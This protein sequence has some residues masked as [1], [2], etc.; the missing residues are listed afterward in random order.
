MS[1]AR[2]LA[3]AIDVRVATRDDAAALLQ[4]HHA[5][6]G[7]DWSMEQWRWRFLDNPLGRTAIAGAFAADGRCLAAFCGVPLRCRYRG[8]AGEVV[9]AGDVVVEPRLRRSIAGSTL[10]VRTGDLFFKQFG[11]GPVRIV[12]GC[13][14]PPLL[15]TATRHLRCE[16]LGDLHGL[17]R[18][19][20]PQVASPPGPGVVHE[21]RLPADVAA[22][23][24]RCASQHPT[25]LL[26]DTRYLAWRY[27]HN[28]HFDYAVHS[29]RAADG[30]LRGLAIVRSGGVHPEALS[31]VEW[32][33]P[34]G[35]DLAEQALVGSALAE[36]RTRG[37]AFVVASFPPA[38]REFE[39][40]Q[41]AHGFRVRL[42]PHQL[43]FRTYS[44]GVDRRFLFEE[45][46]YTL[47][48]FDF[49]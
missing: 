11:G 5:G 43:V 31:V 49:A 15:R 24:A 38:T 21:N 23:C 14:E 8:E 7:S 16:I 30:T 3:Q 27:A 17:V 19:V 13:P 18:A 32:L 46:F 28:P 20:Q 37:L 22:L 39:R 4:L 35:D 41:V 1:D 48:D 47:G 10:L 44:A 34:D 45:W 33:V 25:G 2:L 26:R 6:F 9:R 40:F 29:A 12:Y 36:A 42:T